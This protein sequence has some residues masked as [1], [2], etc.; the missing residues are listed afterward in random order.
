MKGNSARLRARR[1]RLE[2]TIS[3]C[4]P[5]PRSHSPHR[6]AISSSLCELINAWPLG[7]SL[8]FPLRWT[9]LL[10]QV[11]D[12]IAKLSRLLVVLFLFGLV[13]LAPQANQLSVVIGAA[14]MSAR[15]LASVLRLAVD[16][17]DQ[18]RQLLFE[19]H[20]VVL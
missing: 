3:L 2:M 18:R 15:P 5:E 19:I 4:G 17:G 7:R 1:M 6:L 11:A 13:H 10:F 8:A 16:V 14:F 12:L 9:F 20:I